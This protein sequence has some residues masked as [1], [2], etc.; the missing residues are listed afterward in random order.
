MIGTANKNIFMIRI[1]MNA[2]CNRLFILLFVVFLHS[3][4]SVELLS[5][6]L[7]TIADHAINYSLIDFF[8]QF[9][10]QKNVQFEKYDFKNILQKITDISVNVDEDSWVRKIDSY[11]VNN[12][13][14]FVKG[15]S[16]LHLCVIVPS[17]NFDKK[18]VLG[19]LLKKGFLIDA[20]D[21]KKRTVLHYLFGARFTIKSDPYRA[22]KELQDVIIEKISDNKKASYF[23]L[24]DQEGKTA[25]HYACVQEGLDD[26]LLTIIEN[27]VLVT[28]D[29][30]KK[31]DK[32]GNTILH[33]VME[34]ANKKTALALIK[35]A[36]KNCSE[37]FAINN[38]QKE[39]PWMCAIKKYKYDWISG[40]LPLLLEQE[41]DLG[42]YA[43]Q[44]YKE[45]LEVLKKRAKES[46][47]LKVA[48]G[49]NK[50]LAKLIP[51]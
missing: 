8:K 27:D 7:K 2:K 16:P 3:H 37:V 40:V 31:Q 1:A 38:D 45:F 30:L 32:S 13:N 46:N 14:Y 33:A 11:I 17:I 23:A 42:I 25:L 5:Y 18:Y 44:E 34:Q 47:G 41:K 10:I 51:A 4:G 48:L 6:S 9:F 36:A 50:K 19:E 15:M 43:N 28:C 35:K 24:Q 39:T 22:D 21:A 26:S 20:V 29:L 49:K 12:I